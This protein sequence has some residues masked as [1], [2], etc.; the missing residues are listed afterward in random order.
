MVGHESHGCGHLSHKY[1]ASSEYRRTGT[2]STAATPS[3][4]I[5]QTEEE[6]LSASS[7]QVSQSDQYQ[8][9]QVRRVRAGGKGRENSQRVHPSK[10][11]RGCARI[12]LSGS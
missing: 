1:H 6:K 12:Q 2:T 9:S 4:S 8:P 5:S 7:S 11:K 10:I 3:R